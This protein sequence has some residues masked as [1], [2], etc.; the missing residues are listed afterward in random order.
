[1][2]QPPRQLDLLLL[3]E[4]PFWPLDQGFKVHGY[5]TA[6][7]ARERGADVAIASLRPL[8][9]D[10]PAALR[11]LHIDWPDALREDVMSFRGGWGLDA[12][13]RSASPMAWLRNRLA[14]HQGLEVSRLA[15]AVQLVRRLRPR[16]IVAVGQHGAAILRGL[17]PV[18][19]S[20]HASTVWFAADELIAF[21]LSCMRREPIAHWPARLRTLALHAGLENAF[22]RGLDASIGVSPRDARL[23]RLLA[24]TREALTLRNGVDLQRFSPLVPNAAA[25]AP[26]SLAFW[27]RLD[28]E[29]NADAVTWF[30]QAVW[31]E[32]HRRHAD[33]RWLIAGKNPGPA[34]QALRGRPGIELLGEVEDVR[35]VA[36]AATLTVLPMRCGGGIKNKLLE[37]A[38]MARP[39][40]ASPL[41][42]SGLELPDR[43]EAVRICRSPRQWIESICSLWAD[44]LAAERLGSAGRAWVEEKHAWSN[45]AR[46]LLD[47]VD[48]R[49]P[50]GVPPQAAE[51][52]PRLA[53]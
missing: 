48:A 23:L 35:G 8:P 28:F 33:A 2:N 1:M 17:A 29:P 52:A 26:R 14:S 42:V 43:A 30:A 34:V 3:T 20:V 44:P 53:A 4:R 40:V 5:H 22:A 51:H 27:G 21:N 39:I 38:A 45:V 25:P 46:G 37:A 41:C 9:D 13:G 50:R 15:G 32:L 31:P 11:E 19:A 16:A 36:H 18:A 47:W 12:A 10:A 6:L 49:H 7:A 24:G